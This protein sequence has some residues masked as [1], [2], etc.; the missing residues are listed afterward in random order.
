[1]GRGSEYWNFDKNTKSDL[2]VNTMEVSFQRFDSLQHLQRHVHR[3]EKNIYEKSPWTIFRKYSIKNWLLKPEPDAS[4][5][6]HSET[7]AYSIF[8]ENIM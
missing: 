6:T 3:Y 4:L 8:S 5:G 1:M 7:V 2:F